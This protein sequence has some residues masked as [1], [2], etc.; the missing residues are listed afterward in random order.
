MDFRNEYVNYSMLS[1]KD[2]EAKGTWYE[3][4]KI[5]ERPHPVLHMEFKG[6]T[7]PFAFSHYYANLNASANY[8]T[9][10]ITNLFFN[11]F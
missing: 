1:K 7:H 10:K 8:K 3:I 5:A 9:A 4:Q 6:T 11:F 2:G